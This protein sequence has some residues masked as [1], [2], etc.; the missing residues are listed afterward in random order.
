[1]TITQDIQSL[2]PGDLVELFELDAT[3]LGGTLLRFNAGTNKLRSPVIWQGNTYVPLPID[4]SGFEFSGKGQLPRPTLKVAN[5]GGL[6]TAQLRDFNDLLG[7]KVTR[8]RT[9]AKYLDAANFPA[10]RNLLLDT[11]NFGGASWTTQAVTSGTGAAYTPAGVLAQSVIE[12]TAATSAHY[13]ARANVFTSGQAYTLSAS[14]CERSGSAK[15]YLVLAF[16]AG[17]FGILT[18]ALFDLAT[19]KVA[20]TSAG[21][22]AT[23][24]ELA[25]SGYRCT[26]TATATASVSALAQVRLA[27]SSSNANAYTGD[28]ASGLDVWDPQLEQAAAATEY[29]PIGATWSQNPNADPTA[30]LPLDVFFVD[31]KAAENKVVVEF[32]L[33]AAFDVAGV[34]LPRRVV[35]QNVCPWQ[36][37]VYDESSACPYAGTSYW[38]A[39]D[40]PVAS[41]G[42]DVCGKRLSSC[43]LRF[44]ATGQ[45]FFGGFPGAG[46]AR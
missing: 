33:A 15:R 16:G 43:K 4:A 9:L 37:R 21:C 11:G 3:A 28:G 27:S 1:M 44:G 5:I 42:Q 18:W 13:F 7:A 12:T 30:E 17:A 41:A 38:D 45:L 35:A 2:R 29:Q 39:N 19:G 10:R 6:V 40:N 14:A 46:L 26:A 36:Y 20:S 34:Q 8:R 23:I 22:T 32:E 25:P 24:T 31:R